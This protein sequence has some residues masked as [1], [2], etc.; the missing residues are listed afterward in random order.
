LPDPAPDRG[1]PVDIDRLSPLISTDDDR[2]LEMQSP[3]ATYELA[4]TR[5][6][7]LLSEAKAARLAAQARAHAAEG[8]PSQWEASLGRVRHVFAAFSALPRSPQVRIARDAA[9]S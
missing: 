9:R 2:R 3:Y 5:Q 8:K 1:H 6:Q 7:D 4:R